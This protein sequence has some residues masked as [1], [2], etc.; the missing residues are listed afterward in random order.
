[1]TLADVQAKLAEEGKGYFLPLD[2]PHTRSATLGGI[3]ATNDSGPKRFL[4]GTAR[5]VILGI[6]AV[7]P[8]GDIV[9]AGGKT[10]KNVSGYDMT[11][12]LIGSLGTLGII[13]QITFRIYPR[14]D[15]EA[16]LL[17]PF[18]GLK[19]AD[20]FLHKI[21]HSKFF[22][23]AMELMT[24]K[25]A[26][27]LKEAADLK[28]SYVAAIGL[29]GIVEAVERQ[30]AELSAMGRQD[31]ALDVVTL[32]AEN[33]QGFWIAY[34]DFAEEWIKTYP[35]LICLKSNFAISKYAEMMAASEKAVLE[36]GLAG[37]LTCHAGNGIL[38][39]AL[40]MGGELDAKTAVVIDLICRLTAEAVKNE[41]NLVVVRA[42]R[43]IKEKVSVWGQTRSDAVMV[44]RLKEKL[45]PSGILN[46]G[47]FA[48]GV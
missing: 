29:E 28:G 1:V 36:A 18:N 45:D 47:R 33:H 48:A 32:K 19:E 39:T 37:A 38:H 20:G 14:L 40:L 24:A 35:N 31:G 44:R 23:A 34:R 21:L 46:P 25:T 6:K 12:L 4:Y 30:I 3:V 26:A 7:F 15:S 27:G 10:V 11:K 43:P 5:D 22:P 41:G 16:T 42:P 17:I 2:P 8:N 9:V 13:C